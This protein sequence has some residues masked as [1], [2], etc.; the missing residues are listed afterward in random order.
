MTKKKFP[1]REGDL[2]VATLIRRA[3]DKIWA[4]KRNGM[5]THVLF[6]FTCENCGQRC[7]LEEPNTIFEEG[8]CFECKHKTKIEF[9]GY[10]TVTKI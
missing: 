3:Q 1:P 8:E 5:Y 9:G 10:S 6:K 4:D 7:T 2:P